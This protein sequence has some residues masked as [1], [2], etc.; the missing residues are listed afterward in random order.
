MRI[1]KA[2]R[3]IFRATSVSGLSSATAIS[4]AS[5]ETGLLTCTVSGHKPLAE[6]Y[7]SWVSELLLSLFIYFEVA[8]KPRCSVLFM[9]VD[10]KEMNPYAHIYNPHLNIPFALTSRG[11]WCAVVH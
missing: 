3:D 7:S 10:N 5:A 8:K 1:S 9:H 2:S 4:K 6:G 11:Y